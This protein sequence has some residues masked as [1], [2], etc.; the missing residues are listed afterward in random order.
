VSDS[1]CHT[2]NN[3]AVCDRMRIA[4]SMLAREIDEPHRNGGF[5]DSWQNYDKGNTPLD[6]H[7]P[8]LVRLRGF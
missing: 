2:T 8:F 4:K 5:N 7:Q 6:R 3:V 1:E